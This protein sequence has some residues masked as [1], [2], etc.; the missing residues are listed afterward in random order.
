MVSSYITSELCFCVSVCTIH[1]LY[2]LSLCVGVQPSVVPHRATG[3]P[4]G[5]I[6]YAAE[7]PTLSRGLPLGK[8]HTIQLVLLCTACLSLPH[9]PHLAEIPSG[10]IKL[11][12]PEALSSQQ[13]SSANEV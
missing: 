11:H 6:P 13:G 10:S 4:S 12:F 1:M 9:S 8:K 2:V 5:S 7:F 3:G